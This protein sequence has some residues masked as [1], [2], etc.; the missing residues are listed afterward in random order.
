ML[1]DRLEGLRAVVLVD[2]FPMYDIPPFPA[3]GLSVLLELQ[4]RRGEYR[5]LFDGGPSFEVLERNSEFL[6][7]DLDRLDAIFVSTGLE[8]HYGGVVEGARRGMWKGVPIISP[9]DLGLGREVPPER[10]RS[11]TVVTRRFGYRIEETYL[12]LRVGDGWVLLTGCCVYGV[13]WLRASLGP[14]LG[15]PVELLMGGLNLS[16]LDFLGLDDLDKLVREFE[17]GDVVPLH[18]VSREAREYILNRYSH[19]RWSGVGL[20]VEL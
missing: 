20:E 1:G 5:L 16:T 4:G 19:L 14:P 15:P 2:D 8:H 11:R 18:S 10:L 6:E 12:A 17:V 3:H 9:V 7:E 13:D